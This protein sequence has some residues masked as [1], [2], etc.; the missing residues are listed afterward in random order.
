M[1]KKKTCVFISGSGTNL[2]ALINSSRNYNFPI[3]ISYIVSNTK[4][5]KGLK[6][7]KLYG[8]PNDI[9][10][11]NNKLKFEIFINKLKNK[12]ISLICLAGYMK[13]LNKNFIS[14]FK[15]K[16]LNVHPSL[17]PKYKGLD[18]FD[19][20]LKSKDKITGCTVH[21]VNEKLDSGKIIL[22]KKVLIE[23]EDNNQKLKLKVQK[24][25]YR[26]YSEAIYKIFAN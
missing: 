21:Y 14:R 8:I 3:N 20:V 13:I 25:E 6:Y 7:G 5:A 9:I 24:Q 10:D 22:Q 11:L 2:K 4:K 17:L 23:P 18:T 16:I 19:R 1:V 12:N 26:A 15:K